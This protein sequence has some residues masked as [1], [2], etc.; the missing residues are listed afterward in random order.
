[1]I[2]NHSVL[3]VVT[4]R[5]GSKGLPRKNV[6]DTGGRPM[7]AWSIAAGHESRYVDRTILSSEDAEIIQVARDCGCDVPFVRPTELADD[8]SSIYDALFHA[9]DNIDETFDYIVLLQATSPLR[10]ADDIDGCLR[11]CF[12]SGAPACVSVY[13][14]QKSPYLSY[15]LDDAG[16][17]RPLVPMPERPGRRQDLP[18][19]YMLNGAVF[20]ARIDWLRKY[21]TFMHEDTI[22]HVMPAERSLDVD[23]EL[24]HLFVRALLAENEL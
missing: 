13:D 17:L 22:G 24:D 20:V 16:K 10:S 8:D 3:A 11:M 21:G 7:V 2:D 6:R 5:G 12:D 4:A 18:P 1:M 14:P 15:T 23:D 9:L 19:A